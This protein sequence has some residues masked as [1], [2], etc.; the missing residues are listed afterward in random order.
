MERLKK[1]LEDY[2]EITDYT[3]AY[4]LESG[5]Q[6]SFRYSKKGF[7]HMAGLHKLKDIPL[8]QRFNNPNDKMV[9]AKY[10]I[11][12][13]R[14]GRLTENVL[15]QS[16]FFSMIEDRYNG[17]TAENLLSIT[18]T[19]VII[20]FDRMLLNHSKLYNT[21]YILYEETEKGFHQLCIARDARAKYYAETFFKEQSD[22]YI[23]GQRH[24]K[25]QK[26]KIIHSDGTIYLQDQFGN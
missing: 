13:I 25:I 20:N 2:L 12:K 1:K 21:K 17:F 14:Q 11:S 3:I 5:T 8:I 7:P 23:K 26:V 18:Y 16:C 4:E 19:D 24:E 9:N 15:K 10:I 22:H 6:L